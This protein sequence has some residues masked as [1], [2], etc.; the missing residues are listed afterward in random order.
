VFTC[1]AGHRTA[2]VADPDQCPECGTPD[3]TQET[4]VLDA[5]FPQ[6]MWQATALGW[7]DGQ[8]ALMAYYP[9]SLTV[10][11]RDSLR[12][13][14]SKMLMVGR[15]MTGTLPFGNIVVTCIVLR[16]DK[17][18]MDG[19]K[20]TAIPPGP[21]LE[22]HGAD[23][24]RG[25][26][27][28]SAMTGQNVAFDPGVLTGWR[29][30]II[31]LWN[32]VQL[33]LRSGSGVPAGVA[34]G[35]TGP[36]TGAHPEALRGATPLNGS[37]DLPRR[38]IMSRLHRLTTVTTEGLTNFEFHRSGQ[39]L[40][41]FVR[42]D[43]CTHYLPAVKPQLRA[44]DEQVRQ[45]AIQV[46][47]LVLRLLHPFLPFV[48]EELWHQLPGDRPLLERCAWP[49]ADQFAVD[50]EAEAHMDG[51]LRPRRRAPGTGRKS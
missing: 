13:G 1:R 30:T 31:S 17:R 24:L 6:A 14:L 36:D 28:L 42:A 15:E 35:V 33:V 18:K 41:E 9:T 34:G 8:D 7:P 40:L 39:A 50:I 48:T 45:D 47:D 3:L 37:A 29:R 44:G 46:L 5:W 49:E 27:V 23:A 25:W 26:A 21:L 51:V 4:D 11:S 2:S 10:A 16:P 20:G 32:A 22:S 38:W 19:A 12:L 43:L